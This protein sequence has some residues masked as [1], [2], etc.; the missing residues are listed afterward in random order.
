M[1]S[2]ND[3]DAWAEEMLKSATELKRQQLPSGSYQK[4]LAR[5]NQPKSEQTPIRWIRTAAAIFLCLIGL[6]LYLAHGAPEENNAEIVDLIP[7]NNN[8]LYDE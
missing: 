3:K 6:E 1:K 5:I 4:I 7:E 2:V 8:H